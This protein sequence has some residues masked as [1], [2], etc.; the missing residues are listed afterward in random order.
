MKLKFLLYIPIAVVYLNGVP[1]IN[2]YTIITN[3]LMRSTFFLLLSFSILCCCE[4]PEIKITD[5]NYVYEGEI[6]QL[7][8]SS[9]LLAVDTTIQEL[10]AIINNN[11]GNEETQAALEEAIENKEAIN[12]KLAGIPDIVALGIVPPRPPCPDGDLCLPSGFQYLISDLSNNIT[13]FTVLD[14]QQNPLNDITS[15]SANGLPGSEEEFEYQTFDLGQYS[16]PIS[17]QLTKTDAQNNT[18]N[19]SIQAFKQ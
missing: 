3:N 12:V 1:S 18:I 6:Y 4:N 10:E 13:T 17:I 11:Q 5:N 15:A 14:D 8:L 16:G 7:Y 2:L 9:E 19:Y